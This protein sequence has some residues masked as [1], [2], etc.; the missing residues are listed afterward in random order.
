[1]YDDGFSIS[2]LTHQNKSLEYV[3]CRKNNVRHK[4]NTQTIRKS[5][6]WLILYWFAQ[7]TGLV[8]N[9]AKKTLESFYMFACEKSKW[10]RTICNEKKNGNK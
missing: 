10:K 5:V 1:M 8:N 7:G 2:A 9:N 6:D 3:D 4:L